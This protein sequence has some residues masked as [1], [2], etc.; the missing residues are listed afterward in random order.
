MLAIPT[1]VDAS[2]HGLDGRTKIG[3]NCHSGGP[4][5]AQVNITGVPELYTPGETYELTVSLLG[6]PAPAS[7]GHIGGFNLAASE[8]ELKAPPGSSTV[9]ITKEGESRHQMGDE[10]GLP[11]N[12][13]TTG[14]AV[15]THEGANQRIWQVMWEAPGTGEGQVTFN[16]AGNSVDGDHDTPGDSWA[17]NSYTSEEGD[18]SFWQMLE[19]NLGVLLLLTS[20][21]GIYGL[22]K[23]MKD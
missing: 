11:D 13:Q 18:R 4:D 5:T 8:G 21:L 16:V 14:D 6:G 7:V 22:Y 12:W 15:H 17:L 2:S 20:C 23:W 3:C 1:L 9:F 10:N 19:Q